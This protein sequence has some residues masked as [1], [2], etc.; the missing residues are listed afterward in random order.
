MLTAFFLANHFSIRQ[1]INLVAFYLMIIVGY[2]VISI[3][4]S[5]LVLKV[6]LP[7][8]ISL[9]QQSSMKNSIYTSATSYV[10]PPIIASSFKS[11]ITNSPRALLHTTLHPAFH[12]SSS[13]LWKL[14]SL[15]NFMLIAL[16][17][18]NILALFKKENMY[19]QFHLFIVLLTICMYVLIGYTC[20]LEAVLARFKTPLLPFLLSGVYLLFISY[21]NNITKHESIHH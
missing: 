8:L 7:F 12:I 19:F 15:E 16:M 2:F 4:F 11:I 21:K 10:Q 20:A 1:K 5:Q 17:L 9:T 6:D 3:L 18:L 13:W 14:A